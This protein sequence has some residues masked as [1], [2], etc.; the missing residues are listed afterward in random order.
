MGGSGPVVTVALLTIKKSYV[1]LVQTFSPFLPR[2]TRIFLRYSLI[3]Y[4][5]LYF[6]NVYLI[7]ISFQLH[8]RRV[9]DTSVLHDSSSSPLFKPSLK[10]LTKQFLK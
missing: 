2:K 7:F 3:V 1:N 10:C 4:K 9:I 8:H 6:S 5:S